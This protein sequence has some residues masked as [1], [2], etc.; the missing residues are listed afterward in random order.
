MLVTVFPEN[1]R[2]GWCL[3]T[4]KPWVWIAWEK[5]PLQAQMCPTSAVIMWENLCPVQTLPV[6][7]TKLMRVQHLRSPKPSSGSENQKLPKA[8]M[9]I[10]FNDTRLSNGWCGAG[11]FRCYTAIRQH[12]NKH[13]FQCWLQRFWFYSFNFLLV[14]SIGAQACTSLPKPCLINPTTLGKVIPEPPMEEKWFF[15]ATKCLCSL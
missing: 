2:G 1:P 9:S 3:K 12:W 7:S 6:A 10:F 5:L 14:M 11:I 4:S 13:T 15:K 8:T